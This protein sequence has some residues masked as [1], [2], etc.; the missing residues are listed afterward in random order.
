MGSLL[1]RGTLTTVQKGNFKVL[2]GAEDVEGGKRYGHR[3][4]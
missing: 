3:V 4:G 1:R 2:P